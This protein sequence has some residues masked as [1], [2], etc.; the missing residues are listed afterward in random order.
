M[1]DHLIISFFMCDKHVWKMWAA[2]RWNMS[3]LRP[4]LFPG[5][6]I[7]P[8]PRSNLDDEQLT[9]VF[10]AADLC[11]YFTDICFVT[12][13]P[14]LGP[15]TLRSLNGSLT[16]QQQS[17]NTDL[18]LWCCSAKI[19]ILNNKY[20]NFGSCSSC[21]VP[22]DKRHDVLSVQKL[23][24]T[25]SLYYIELGGI[26]VRVQVQ[27]KMTRIKN[28]WEN[29]SV[30]QRTRT[31]PSLWLHSGVHTFAVG[32]VPLSSWSAGLVSP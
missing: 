15:V 31:Y 22:F 11:M 20:S 7:S 18:K 32:V 1:V 13:V 28:K 8:Y 14:I 16:L 30:Q 25:A 2:Y 24:C 12:L 10:T 23:Y 6:N 9:C 29:A 17:K 26:V 27:L 3:R 21:R 5:G 4:R 19:I